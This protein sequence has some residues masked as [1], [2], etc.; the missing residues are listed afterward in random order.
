MTVSADLRA[1]AEA[2]GQSLPALLAQAE[3]LAAT[4]GRPL[5]NFALFAPRAPVKPVAIAD[6]VALGTPEPTP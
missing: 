2:L 5:D 3:H 1:R 6:I 4:Q